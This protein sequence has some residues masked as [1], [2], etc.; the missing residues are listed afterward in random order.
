MSRALKKKIIIIFRSVAFQRV[1]GRLLS[2]NSRRLSPYVWFV[3]AHKT[4]GGVPIRVCRILRFYVGP[5]SHLLHTF[6]CVSHP[7][8]TTKHTPSTRE[9]GGS[10]T[11]LLQPTPQPSPAHPRPQ[12]QTA[13]TTSQS[14]THTPHTPLSQSKHDQAHTAGD[15]ARAFIARR[16]YTLLPA[17][18]APSHT[19]R[20]HLPVCTSRC[21]PTH[22]DRYAF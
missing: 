6:H 7:R 1:L 2:A 19:C 21:R 22:K 17:P 13:N 12:A 18:P 5:L 15:P 3:S 10:C 14:H 4:R 11:A 8:D 9:E 20:L 16:T